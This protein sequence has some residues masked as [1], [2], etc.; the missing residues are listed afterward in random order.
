MEDLKG[1]MPN[2]AWT[3]TVTSREGVTSTVTGS[4]AA[5]APAG[6][7][8]GA[9]AAAPSGGGTLQTAA[10]AGTTAFAAETTPREGTSQQPAPAEAQPPVATPPAAA[11]VTQPPSGNAVHSPQSDRAGADNSGAGGSADQAE[12]SKT[13]RFTS[14]VE[15]LSLSI[16]RLE[17]K[18]LE[19]LAL[20]IK[21]SGD[22][23]GLQLGLGLVAGF[24]VSGR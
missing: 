1:L 15:S 23:G 4:N 5:R 12:N 13:E 6:V 10:G 16:H 3:V 9:S 24:R 22:P 17:N 18:H 2:V 20:L 11:D 7:Q 14:H 21:D 8:A 19:L